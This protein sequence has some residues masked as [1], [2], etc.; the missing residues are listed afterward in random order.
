[1]F[2]PSERPFQTNTG[3]LSQFNGSFSVPQEDRLVTRARELV[4]G[5][6]KQKWA[7][8]LRE[9]ANQGPILRSSIPA[10]NFSD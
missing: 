7:E 2:G 6:L 9:A 3:F 10:E 4:S 1:V 8:T 5:P